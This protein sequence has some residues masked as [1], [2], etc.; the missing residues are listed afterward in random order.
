MD[1]STRYER[2]AVIGLRAGT[3]S[4]IP[5]WRTLPVATVTELA[6]GALGQAPGMR[7]CLVAG[8][9]LL[10]CSTGVS[11]L[12]AYLRREEAHL[13]LGVLVLRNAPGDDREDHVDDKKEDYSHHDRGRGGW[14]GLYQ[15]S[16]CRHWHLHVLSQVGSLARAGDRLLS[17]PITGRSSNNGLA[18]AK[19]GEGGIRTLER[20]YPRYAI[21]SRA[22]ST[23]PAPLQLDGRF[24]ATTRALPPLL[25]SPR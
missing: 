22:R 2:A 3:L 1:T 18:P 20:G 13:N 25:G 24:K 12:A 14:H 10:R 11:D 16:P 5:G 21:S 15:P 23:A 8:A 19:N 17:L 7:L 9:A 4:L 6:D